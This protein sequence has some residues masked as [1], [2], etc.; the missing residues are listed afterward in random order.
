MIESITMKGVTS[1]NSPQPVTVDTNKKVVFLY[2]HNGTG[3]STVARFLQS[4]TSPD[5]ANCSYTLPNPQDYQILV[6]NTD[7]VE[8]NFSQDSFEGVFTLGES[9]VAAEQAIAAA[10]TKITDLEARRDQKQQLKAQLEE[11]KETEI[12][13]VLAKVFETK[14]EHDKRDLDHCLIGYKNSS[15]SFYAELIKIPLIPPPDYTFKDLA[16]ESKELNDKSA[17]NKELLSEIKL[18]LNLAESN[19]IFDEVIVG[20][21]ESY[22][23]SLVEKLKNLSWIDQGRNFIDESD[24]KCPFC[25][26]TIDDKLASEINDLF[27]STY[28][29]KKYEIK[30]IL[31]T[32]KISLDNLKN[33][34]QEESYQ[35]LDN[36]DFHLAKE[37]LI[38]ALSDNIR[39]INSKLS[40]PSKKVELTSTSQLVTTIN[41]VIGCVNKERREFNSKLDKKKESLD[42]IK[43]KFWSLVRI[44][45]NGDILSHNSSIATIDSNI[46]LAENEVENLMGSINSQKE[47]IDDNRKMI[48]N[49]KTSIININQKIQSI[50]LEGFEIKPK[51]DGSNTY[52]LCR[53]V[54]SNGKDVYKSLSEGEKTLVTYLYFLELCQGS[55]DSSSSTPKN[56]KI[57]VIDD[58]ISSLSHNY[59]YEI[60]ALTYKKLIKGYGYSQVILLTHSLYFIH[61]MMKYLPNKKPDFERKCNLY[62]FVKN[63]HSNIISMERGDIKNDYQSYWQIIKDA[64]SG[65]TNSIILPNTMRNILE[66]Y[67]SF[68]HKNDILRE[69]LDSLEESDA[70]F[71]PF[72]R[73]INRESHSDSVNINDLAEIDSNRFIDKFREVFVKTHFEE[74][75]DKMMS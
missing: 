13:R 38:S 39:L 30:S 58:P 29:D 51:D 23:S 8:A 2:G 15:A 45:Y 25:Q 47:I 28:K 53:G 3:K 54:S 1:F 24:G 18:D 35:S 48:T 14:K 72:F 73:F 40:E 65:N 75:Y 16:N 60:G 9:N 52:Y 70:E 21:S 56:K 42:E 27:D 12:K 69:A 17:V 64:I 74:H 5:Y 4:P 11:K 26:Q 66:Y 20:T 49:I 50:G 43:K 31:D 32:Y 59:I 6:Y 67:F 46:K 41:E 7:F 57:I 68:V 62:R 34:F 10:E 61:E 33:K 44:K 36:T 71:S 37:K 19:V 63:S 55:V 22:L